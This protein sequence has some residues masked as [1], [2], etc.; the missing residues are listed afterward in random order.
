MID[1]I[2]DRFMPH[3]PLNVL[4]LCTGNSARSILA[5]ALL[6]HLGKGRF[7][8][9]SAG[10]QPVG[11]VHPLAIEAL[12]H[13]GIAATGLRSKSWDEFTRTD[14]PHMDLVITLCDDAAGETCP[15]WPGQPATAHWDYP[16]PAA[17]TGPHES[18]LAAFEHTLREMARRLELFINLPA[19]KVDR[20]ALQAHARTVV[21][22]AS[23]A[24]QHGDTSTA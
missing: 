18:R 6:N 23:G 16:D 5:E 24:V 4:F 2:C 21:P 8:A 3:E 11:S 10:S 17:V 9:H 19:D 13:A 1:A 22:P 15:C 7:R 20:L 14:A 12:T